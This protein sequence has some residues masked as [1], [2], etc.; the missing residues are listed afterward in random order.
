M[1]LGG[2]ESGFLWSSSDKKNPNQQLFLV[3]KGQ[4]SSKTPSL[5]PIFKYLQE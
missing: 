5:E 3:Q 4:N 2:R 1:I